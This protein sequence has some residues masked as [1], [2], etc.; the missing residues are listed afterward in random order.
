MIVISFL[1]ISSS[2]LQ[3]LRTAIKSWTS[4]ILGQ[5]RLHTEGL[6]ALLSSIDLHLWTQKCANFDGLHFML[7]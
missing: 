4:S 7:I 2:D 3:I 1:I 5:I 6:L